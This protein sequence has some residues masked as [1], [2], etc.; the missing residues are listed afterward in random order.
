MAG[1]QGRV[2]TTTVAKLGRWL[3]E[4]QKKKVGVVSADVLSPRSY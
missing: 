4:N 3:Q 1:L 2:K